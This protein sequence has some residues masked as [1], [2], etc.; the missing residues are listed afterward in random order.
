MLRC[1]A[2]LLW[3]L[4]PACTLPFSDPPEPVVGPAGR[5]MGV[6]VLPRGFGAERA[7][8][9][10]VALRDAATAEEVA[11]AAIDTR[12]A[13]LLT[14]VGPGSYRLVVDVPGFPALSRPVTIA[15]DQTVD[16]GRLALSAAVDAV[17]EGVARLAG[18][19]EGGH[20]GIY[21]EARGTPFV[22]ATTGDGRYRLPLSAGRHD[23]QFV[24]PGYNVETRSVVVEPVARVTVE[25]VVLTGAP[26]AVRGR[27]QLA[28]LATPERLR[29]VTVAL[30]RGEDSVA[31]VAPEESGA[32]VF[33]EVPPGAYTLAAQL[34]GYAG[35]SRAVE[36]AVGAQV[37]AGTLVL[38][39]ESAR[40]EAV[41]LRGEV[42]LRGAD[43]H[44]GTLVRV[45]LAEGDL[46][47]AV[48]VTDAAGGFDVPASDDDRYRLAVERPGW[49]PPAGD[50]VYVWTGDGFRDERDPA[51]PIRLELL[52]VPIDGRV[53]VAVDISPAW[54]PAAARFATVRVEGP[55]VQVRD[56]APAEEPV[57]FAGLPAGTYTVSVDR[58]GF[59]GERHRVTLSPA[60]PA[61]EVG[62][63]PLRLVS[64]AAAALDLDG[65]ALRDCVLRAG[66]DLR[67]ANLSG[68][69]LTGDFGEL[70]DE[71]CDR[72]R[73]AVEGEVTCAALDLS[74]ADLGQADLTAT[75]FA[76]VKLTRAHLASARL[77]GIDLTDADLASASLFGADLGCDVG[78][79][80]RCARLAGA[81]LDGADL[82]NATLARAVLSDDGPLPARP[83]GGEAAA[84]SLR[85]A[86]FA[87]ASLEAVRARGVDFSAASLGG[88]RLAAAQLDAA[89]LAE[90]DLTLVDLS[91]ASLD[92]ADARG[93][94]FTNAVVRE[95]TLR[96]AHLDGA[97]FASAVIERADFGPPFDA[98]G[99]RCV[100]HPWPVAP[101]RPDC[102]GDALVAIVDASERLQL[103]TRGRPAL[104]EA[105]CGGAIGP[106][107]H[108]GLAV[109]TRSQVTV[110]TR[111]PGLDTVLHLRSHCGTQLAE[112]ACNDDI[113]PGNT[114]SRLSVTLDAG[115]YY[116]LVDGF[117]PHDA[118]P[119]EVDI[120]IE[121]LVPFEGDHDQRCAGD[122]R[123][124][125]PR[126]CRTSLRDA[127]LNGANLVGARL[128]HADL[129]GASLLGVTFGDA[130]VAPPAQPAD[131]RPEAYNDCLDGCAVRDACEHIDTDCAARCAEQR[132]GTVGAA[133]DR[134]RADGWAAFG[135]SCGRNQQ[136][137][138]LLAACDG[139]DRPAFPRRAPVCTWA[140]VQAGAC[141]PRRV[142]ATCRVTRSSLAGSRLRE[143][144]LPGVVVNHVDLR[145]ALLGGA[146]LRGAL[147]FDSDVTNTE[148]R[149]ADLARASLLGLEVEQRDLSG[150]SFARADLQNGRF[151]DTVLD[152]T[153]FTGATLDLAR[154]DNDGLADAYQGR[155][156]AFTD[157]RLRG[158][159]LTGVRWP[160]P[161]FR[162]AD[163]SGA[164]ITRASLAD[165]VLSGATLGETSLHFVDLRGAE[166]AYTTVVDG[167]WNSVN[168][169][170]AYFE[171]VRINH[172]YFSAVDLRRA[173][174]FFPRFQRV[175]FQYVEDCRRSDPGALPPGLIDPRRL[176]D[177]LLCTWLDGATLAGPELLDCDLDYTWFGDVVMLDPVLSG[178]SLRSATFVDAEL[179]CTS[180]ICGFTDM[181]LTDVAFER[182]AFRGMRFVNTDFIATRATAS[183]FSGSE[184]RDLTLSDAVFENTDLADTRYVRVHLRQTAFGAAPR[185]RFTESCLD[186]P[187]LA[188]GA[189]L[190]GA[191][192]ED[193]RV[194]HGAGDGLAG[195][196]LAGAQFRRADLRGVDLAGADLAGALFD[197]VDV[198]GAAFAEAALDGA[199]LRGI[200]HAATA[201]WTGASVQGARI[202]RW[203]E[204]A[205]A[206]AVGVPQV[207]DCAPV[208]CPRLDCATR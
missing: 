137:Q 4:L 194:R 193:S 86:T 41:R 81:R 189:N 186:E 80:G 16:I 158:A 198:E 156:V 6:V 133:R 145:G 17:V 184:F 99:E 39:H 177:L 96:G 93:A 140:D 196:L 170:E 50:P 30:R 109:A 103:D 199:D 163:L 25:D 124:A 38:T 144:V 151:T 206:D 149:G 23:L 83:C 12:G 57:V 161:D 56:R 108:V 155:E 11:R 74:G 139:D 66:L 131:C 65:V 61:A 174:F 42:L 107:A 152:H 48:A 200:C 1:A 87:R 128:E 71:A 129:T 53:T 183:T 176:P 122:D 69:T 169:Q 9:G 125:D 179:E 44:A 49:A 164:T 115:F 85:E 201:E 143:A 136:E 46:P 45:R 171:G 67:G 110:E 157:A 59:A 76:G 60:A 126:C 7:A 94:R 132:P 78:G 153:R 172:T 34:A 150:T 101:S 75:R 202:C 29:R 35:D 205:F 100:P 167:A 33:A 123:W 32:F 92:R 27:V 204:D 19:A 127:N 178:G 31:T 190:T 160:A 77:R 54:I 175:R 20:R 117:A 2:I 26:A 13:F 118:G 195:A 62:P 18:V 37:D 197:R 63:V 130:L 180:P 134:C 181:D 84:I 120:H 208:V 187:R 146:D 10:F 105:T 68:V 185:A 64:L 51:A 188:P 24:H 43:D 111:A 147:V 141:E 166:L 40:G 14:G 72:C 119:V 22:T 73:E 36:V 142:P 52:P 162:R 3:C 90:A 106:E 191:V 58:P 95:T 55:V 173:T 192:F 182:S 113:G 121:P 116:L 114:D 5:V 98:G 70:D 159:R 82:T 79:T 135:E 112:L 89:C 97:S 138:R 148:L 154:F 21:V 47:F 28:Q 165:A 102:G 168:A 88:A 203:D 8:E 104:E 91:G 15:E 207:V